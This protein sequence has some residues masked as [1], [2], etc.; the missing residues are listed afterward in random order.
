[1]SEIDKAM[2]Y[3]WDLV[4]GTPGIIAHR[5]PKDS[6]STMGGWYCPHGIYRSEELNGLSVTRFIEGVR[7]EG[8]HSWTRLCIREPLHVHPL[9]NTADIYHQGKPT[10]IANAMRDVR[11]PKGSLPVTESMRAFTVPPF[12]R[13]EPNVIE[14]YAEMFKKVVLHHEELLEGDRGDDWVVPNERGGA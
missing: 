1:M 6:G 12:R 14:Q 4:E 5:P 13:F 11:Q 3:F 9:L 2:N 8:Y 7:A 10:R